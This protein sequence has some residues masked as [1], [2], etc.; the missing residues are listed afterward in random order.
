MFFA[1]GIIKTRIRSVISKTASVVQAKR[2]NTSNHHLLFDELPLVVL[3]FIYCKINQ[4]VVLAF[5]SFFFNL[6]LSFVLYFWLA[7]STRLST[8]TLVISSTLFS[9]TIGMGF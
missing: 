8:L 2:P 4:L 1:D 6:F 7:M 5:L 9:A 3:L